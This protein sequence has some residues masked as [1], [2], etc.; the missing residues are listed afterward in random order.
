MD[1]DYKQDTDKHPFLGKETKTKPFFRKLFPCC[2]CCNCCNDCSDDFDSDVK[3][4][5]NGE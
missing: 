3:V 4:Y 5:Y 1:S 2:D